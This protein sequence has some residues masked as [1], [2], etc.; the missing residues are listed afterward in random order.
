MRVPERRQRTDESILCPRRAR[1]EG[2]RIQESARGHDGI[3]RNVVCAFDRD[4]ADPP[5]GTD[6]GR[7]DRGGACRGGDAGDRAIEVGRPSWRSKPP[8]S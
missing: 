8:W 5:E 4:V 6:R 3:D 2:L 7:N 1:R